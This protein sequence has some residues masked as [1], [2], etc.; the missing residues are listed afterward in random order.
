MVDHRPWPVQIVAC[1]GIS[2]GWVAGLFESQAPPNRP[3]APTKMPRRWHCPHQRQGGG[4]H[5]HAAGNV[6]HSLLSS[7]PISPPPS[8]ISDNSGFVPVFV[9]TQGDLLSGGSI[10]GQKDTC[11]KKLSQFSLLN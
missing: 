3:P 10:K 1:A 2:L 5:Q 7:L 9:A 4:I 6:L 8:F 11:I